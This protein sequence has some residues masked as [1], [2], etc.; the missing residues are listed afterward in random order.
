[1]KKNSTIKDIAKAVG[2]SPAAVSL[3]LNDGPR[4]SQVTRERIAKVAAKLHYRPN[5]VARTLVGSRSNTLGLVITT[6]LNPFYP[7]L[8]KGIEDKAVEL[9]YSIMICSTNYD[10]RHQGYLVDTLRSKGADGII[11][12]SVESEDAN[13]AALLEDD[14][15]FVLVNRKTMTAALESK[16]DYVVMDNVAGGFMAVEHLYRL[17]HRRIG[18]IAG[19][20]NTSTA[21]Q[22]TRGARQALSEFGL[23]VDPHLIAECAF[24]KEEAYAAAGR[25]LSMA[26]PPTAFFAENDYMALGVRQAILDV[27]LEIPEDIALVGFDDIEA[28]GIA[29]VELTT[30]SQ[31]KYEM[32]GRAAQ[33]LIERIEQKTHS[34]QQVVLQPELVIRA[35]CGFRNKPYKTRRPGQGP[36]RRARL[37]TL[38]RVTK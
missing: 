13:V 1:V 4:I 9:G 16:I 27:G 19:A 14:F 30:V 11:F 17:G 26:K 23:A 15:P 29:G 35:S 28:G 37:Q 6:I 8:A 24:S 31:K 12:S 7:E 32:G 34:P 20:L 5:Y 10:S 18:I 36:N 38:E 3:A 33:I 25:Q 21:L 22:R 2:V